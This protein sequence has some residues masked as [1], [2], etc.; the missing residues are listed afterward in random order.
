MTTT[1]SLR[2]PFGA[3]GAE[4]RRLESY[5]QG[6]WVAGSGKSAELFHAVTGDR[7]GETSTGGIDFK[8]VVEYAKR[9]GGP[10]LRRMTFH[11]RARMLKAMAQQLMARKDEF[12]VV[13][14][15]TGATKSDSWVD[16]EG[17]I[18]TL[19]A[20]ASRGRREMPDQRFYIDGPVEML[21]KGG[22]FVGRHICVP[23]EGV[24]VHIN[25][26]NFPVWGMLE[27]LA[28]TL[29]AGMP[30]IVKPATVTAYLT[31]AVFRAMIESGLFPEGAIQLLCGRTGDLLD[32][33]DCQSAVAF[34]GSAATGKMLK[35]SRAILDN[36]VRFNMEADSL[37]YCMLGP[38]AAPG[39]PEF[40]LFVKEVVREMTTKAG[41]KCTAIRRTLVP[42]LLVTAVMDALT[43]RLQGVTVGDP[44]VDGVRMGP[45][46]G[47]GQV[48][49]V[50]KS[51]DSIA[52]AAQLVY[53]NLDDFNVVGADRERGAFFPPLLF[54]SKDPFAATEPH[55]IEAFGPVN[56]V[57][58]YRNVDDA[59]ELAKKGKGSL[60]GSLFTADDRVARDVVM[61]TA[62]YHGRLLLINRESAKE[63]TGHG[64][65]LPHLVHGGPGRAGGGE[66]MGGVRGVLHYMQRTALQGSPTTLMHVT[67]EYVPGAERTYDRV[68]P[69]RKYFD[70]LAVGDAL[71]TARRTVTEADIVNFAG[72]SGDFFYAH[73]D[74][75]AAHDSMFERRVAHGYFVLS[76]AA[77]LFVDPAPGPVLA[78]YGLE[79]LRFVKPVYPGDTIQATLTVK[80][81][82]AKEKKDD[83]PLHG[84]VAWDVEVKNQDGD[85]VAVYTILTL[86]QRR[87]DASPG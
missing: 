69:F 87:S 83:Q 67:S 20:Y 45:L 4:P 37:N 36:N 77:G 19:F 65:P 7:I 62:A 51:V 23:L 40:D 24:A 38:D 72:V 14:A 56:T 80:Q 53:G 74:D 32:H 2:R 64:S 12:Y 31:E 29:L 46:A 1:E 34:T 57:M 48:N 81:K 47:R 22:S 73:M 66:E 86:V 16:I 82:T 84:V 63:S 75:I 52:R 50:R 43:K 25:A 60:V 44:S 59:I 11:E 85:A 76:A 79:T 15:A 18:G 17:G 41:Q 39:T 70:E 33:L 26:F 30:A 27:K 78:N 8:G 61:G 49:E 42:E 3:P 10:A 55:D 54:Y 5:V 35:S 58:P 13:S 9:T 28:P 71:R 21:S 6:Q 68:H